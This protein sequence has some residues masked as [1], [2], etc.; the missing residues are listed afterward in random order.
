MMNVPEIFGEQVFN[1]EVM[2][3]RLP[4]DVYRSL[5]KTIAEGKH[6]Q[7]DLAN[8]V[9]EA[10]KDW[11][12]EKGATH[13]THWFQPMTGVT[14][15]KH[16]SF[17][18]PE[19]GGRVMMEFSGKELVKGEPDASSFPSG[20]LRATFEARG[21]TAWDPTS[22]A[23]IKDDTLCIPTAFCSYS[24]EALD[25]KTPLLRSMQALEKQALRILR[26]FGNTDAKRVLT[27]VGP[28]Q[29]YF[30]IDEKMYAE[31]PDLIYTG[32][33]LFGANPPKGQELDDH[34]FG[35]I[36]PRVKAYMKELDEELWKL[37]I[38]A[39]TEHN[40]VA[41]AQHELAPVYQTT[42]IATDHNQL[43]MELLK[44]VAQRHG[45]VCLLHEKPFAGVN[46]SG[47]HNNWSISTDTGMNLLEPGDTPSQNAQ[48][49][50][51]LVAV[52]KA[53]DDYQGLLRMSVAS[54]GNDHRLG[55]NEA[56][57][58]IMS[59]FLGDELEAVL[60]AIEEGKDYH[61]NEKELM[62]I[63]ASVLPH[64]PKDT[65]DRNRTSPFAFTGNKFE[66]RSLG[67]SASISGPNIILNTIVAQALDEYAQILEGAEDFDKALTRLIRDEVKAHKRILFNGNGYGKEWPEE[68]KKRGLLN[69]PTTVEAMEAF[70]EEKSIALFT[71]HEV[72]SESEIRARYE[73]L[74]ENYYKQIN[75]EALT[76]QWMVRRNILGAGLS[77]ESKLSELIL[78][79]S[80]VGVAAD[81]EK[82]LLERTSR[83]IKEIYDRL[84]KLESAVDGE[85]D[86]ESIP[87][88]ARYHEYT[89]H[90]AM[91]SLR[92]AVDELESIVPRDIW[93]Y[94]T[95]GDLLYS[96]R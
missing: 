35:M 65:T 51:F 49:L 36:K 81:T 31:R 89:I 87:Q 90:E 59:V 7:M 21:Y 72:Y 94:P 40:E 67:S 5:Q 45:M 29:E 91:H 43:T 25:K 48:F 86:I 53:V 1:D 62:S 26:L 9:A 18:S 27:T 44:T 23:F 46:G 33:T 61:D 56:P 68:A 52:I 79:K 47:K 20:G 83:L 76:M 30:L 55:A 74:L 63:G 80:Q 64:I 4:K 95:Y 22:Y 6:L 39:K 34:Y 58:A 54:A 92:E 96:V 73:I 84:E 8:V 16:D 14:A 38:Y 77:Y 70:V 28:E 88:L 41:P 10:M 17:I 32:R 66:F 93:P 85:K 82:K 42:N 19:P 50:L 37:G 13:F 15:E 71:K 75:I 78:K 24:G 57:P 69:L 60:S 3:K 11:A 2:R 12:T